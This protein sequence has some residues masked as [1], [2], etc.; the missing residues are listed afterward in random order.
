[1]TKNQAALNPQRDHEN[2]DGKRDRK[3]KPDIDDE[4]RDGQKENGEN[5]KDADSKADLRMLPLRSGA[6]CANCASATTPAITHL[7]IA[8][9]A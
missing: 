8:R 2:E 7:P 5:R 6:S 4:G 9:R 3:C 1:M